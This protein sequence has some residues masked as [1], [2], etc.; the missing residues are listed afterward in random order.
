MAVSFL[1]KIGLAWRGWNRR[2]AE[3]S[4]RKNAEFLARN[5]WNA[6]VPPAGPAPSSA[7]PPPSS[8]SLDLDRE[9]L[10][11]AYLDDS[12]AIEHYLD[13]ESGEVVEFSVATPLCDVTNNPSRFRKIPTRTLESDAEDRRLFAGA[14]DPGKT[15]DKLAAALDATEFRRVL[16]TDRII[17]RAWYNFKNDR[18]NAAIDAWLRRTIRA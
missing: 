14:L 2:R 15:R 16:A 6:G 18:A 5:S 11:I 17:E 9:G 12:G 3:E 13:V 4:K 7:P 1:Q 8:P 10:Q